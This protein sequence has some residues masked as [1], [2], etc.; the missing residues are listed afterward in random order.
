MAL[1]LQAQDTDEPFADTD[2][3]LLGNPMYRVVSGCAVTYDAGNMTI[4]VAAGVIKHNGSFVAV[5]EQLN[6]VTLVA[7]GSNPRWSYLTLNGSGTVIL[8]SGTPSATPVKPEAPEG[9][10]LAMIKVV[11]GDTIA[12][13]ITVKL[14]K[15][16]WSEVTDVAPQAT[17]IGDAQALGTGDQAARE[18]HVH[19]N[20]APAT[21][22]VIQIGDAAAAGSGTEAARE[23]HE[24][25][26][27][28]PATPTDQDY[29]DSAAAGSGTDP[30]REDHLH[31]MPAGQAWTEIIKPNDETNDTTTLANDSHFQFSV[32]ANGEYIVE[33]DLLGEAAVAADLKIDFSI[34]S[35]TFHL[36]GGE[37]ASG[38][39]T[40]AAADAVLVL[41]GIGNPA[42]YHVRALLLIAGSGGTA[43]FRFA[44]NS[45]Q[46]G[47]VSIE[48]NSL[49][50]YR[51]LD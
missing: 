20:A 21:P 17:S 47:V 36:V 39:F 48:Q 28:A 30:A 27:V 10:F 13:S 2:Y 7:D 12:N 49:M 29:G 15:R 22:N 14:D 16:V 6:V 44:E 18:D 33:F 37:T 1:T 40:T 38:G 43:N 3:E 23:D 19:A 5:S 34:P 25:G 32:V 9:V 31:G 11:N 50:R 51:R 42:L 24:H 45:A 26:L 4:D 8:T 46:A 35:G 41:N